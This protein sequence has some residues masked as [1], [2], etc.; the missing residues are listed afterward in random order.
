MQY[1]VVCF[2]GAM[3]IFII[4]RYFNRAFFTP[5]VLM[6]QISP[7]SNGSCLSY[8]AFAFLLF[9]F[10]TWLIFA[11]PLFLLLYFAFLEYPQYLYFFCWPWFS[12][13]FHLVTGSCSAILLTE[14]FVVLVKGFLLC[15]VQ[16]PS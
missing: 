8:D 4:S 12:P 15:W 11:F 13:F 1:Y 16:H 7:S 14:A 5:N 6:V 3:D 9:I 2:S 10:C